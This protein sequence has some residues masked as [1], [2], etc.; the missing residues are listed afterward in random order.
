MSD[1]ELTPDQTPATEAPVTEA[2]ATEAPSVNTPW[3]ISE[4]QPVPT[5][6]PVRKPATVAWYMALAMSLLAGLVGALLGRS[7]FVG[8]N[9]MVSVNHTV[10]RAP[11]SIAGIA[12]RVSPSVVEIDSES[13][14]GSDTGS[15]FFINSNG[16]I[17]TNNHVVEGAVLTSGKITVKLSNNHMYPA[18]VIGRDTSYD[19]AVLKIDLKNTP[20]LQLGDSSK[21][22]VGD[23]VIAIGSPLGLQGTVTSGIVSAK[24]RPV[25][26]SSDNTSGETSYIDALQTDAAI[27]PGNSGGPLV[28]AS[29][30]VIGVNSAIAS[31][32]QDASGQPGSIGLGFAI[33]V[34]QAKKTADQLIKRGHSTYPIV[35]L[36]LDS[37]FAGPGARIAD[38]PE[39]ILPGG[40][41][42]KAG[43][44]AGDVIIAIDGKP[45]SVPDDMIVAIRSRSVG[46]SVT[47]TYQRGPKTLTVKVTLIASK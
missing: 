43:L 23:A 11:N 35:G 8:S 13:R 47:L 12:A 30:A 24:N 37:A 4:S 16:Y 39:A 10:E 2:P 34:N 1:E 41:A 38:I 25:T 6:L 22:E 32:G 29:G 5:S 14:A 17:M 7:S 18:T 3:W 33:P 26:T 28:D 46:D 20:A 27:N 15:G 31:L 42:Q 19:L 40:P 21:V 36:S 45:V 44:R 9:E